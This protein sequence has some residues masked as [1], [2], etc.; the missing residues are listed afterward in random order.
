MAFTDPMALRSMQGICTRPATGSQV[1]PRLCSMPISAAFSI[2]SL[3]PL[4]AET[5]PAAAQLNRGALLADL[6]RLREASIAARTA[7]SIEPQNP[8]AWI[9]LGNALSRLGRHHDAISALDRA[10]KLQPDNALAAFNRGNALAA[11]GRTRDAI[12]ALLR[13]ISLDPHFAAAA[14]NLSSRLRELGLTEPARDAARLAVQE[15]PALPQAWVTLGNALYD[16]AAFDDAAICQRQAL[17]LDPASLPAQVNLAQVLAAQGHHAEAL[18]LNEA[19]IATAPDMPEP[20][21]G[22]ATCLLALGDYARGWA[23]N[24]ARW[25]Q[26]GNPPRPFTAPLWRG[27]TIAGRK[28][29][30]HAEQG[31]GDTLQ[32]VRFVPRVAELGAKIMLEVQP[33]LVR[34][35]KTL[36]GIEVVPRGAK[37]KSFDLHCPMLDLA[38][39]FATSLEDLAP[40]APYVAA[41]P[42][43]IAARP[44]P[45]TPG[46]LRVGLVWAGKARTE[47]PHALAMDRRR[48]LPLSTFAPL[49][50]LCAEGR[51]A[52]FSLQ[53][54]PPAEQLKTTDLPIA[55]ALAGVT[56]FAETAGIVAQL[57]LV[58][59]VD[60]ST[61]HLAAAMG[62]PVWLLS[63]FDACWRWLHA[64]SDTPWYPSM[65]L[66]RQPGPNDWATPIAEIVARLKT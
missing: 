2:C 59:A 57:D 61:A 26:P 33:P 36:P 38:G 9:N 10:T 54:G 18:A 46:A 58:I 42:D 16:L 14:V 39:I 21:L 32:F 5:R 13:A 29:L 41:Q 63:R 66:F 35:L 4:R 47:M 48:S 11:A 40:A 17:A 60:T 45:A 1:R 49:A 24:Q 51:I 37:L 8:A 53:L 34:L 23:A 20:Q 55:E 12:D 56:D 22:R 6:G 28:I 19:A 44:L 31:L 27:G 62:K 52:L 30:I 65:T 7:T 15:A 25:R 3:L 43:W 50:P 64:R